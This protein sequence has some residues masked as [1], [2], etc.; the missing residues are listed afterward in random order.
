LTLNDPMQKYST[1]F[2]AAERSLI[3]SAIAIGALSLP[4]AVVGCASSV[5]FDDPFAEYLQRTIKVATTGGDSQAAN[6]AL[7]T[8]EPWP[9]YANNTHILADGARMTRAVQRYENGTGGESAP[10]ASMNSGP[11]AAN[12]PNAASTGVL[13]SATA[14]PPGQY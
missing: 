3:R 10:Q 5:A 12:P 7:Q 2:R 13:G 11:S 9:R 6:L 8:A 1:R 14:A 4:M